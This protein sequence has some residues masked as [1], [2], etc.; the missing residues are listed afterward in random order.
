MHLDYHIQDAGL[1]PEVTPVRVVV[2]MNSGRRVDV[3]TDPVRA[4]RACDGTHGCEQACNSDQVR[5]VTGVNP[6]GWTSSGTDLSRC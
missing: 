1:S 4:Q 6:L 5:G 2:F 3:L